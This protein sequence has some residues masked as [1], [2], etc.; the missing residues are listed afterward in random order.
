[1]SGS[2]PQSQLVDA[3]ADVARQFAADAG[4]APVVLSDRP[5]G[6]VVRVG[7]VVAKAHAPGSDAAA[8]GERLRAA[9]A[10]GGR[11]HRAVLLAPTFAEPRVV[12]ERLVSVW[13]ACTPLDPTAPDDAPWRHIG[14][15]LGRLHAVDATACGVDAGTPE[16]VVRALRALDEL[17]PSPAVAAVRAAF[18][19]LPRALLQGPGDGPRVLVHGDLHLG[20]VVRMGDGALRLID[21]DD[22]GRGDPRWDLA[23]PAA[24]FA[25][26]LMA[27][28]EWTALLR[29]YLDEGGAGWLTSWEA[30]DAFARAM[31]VQGAARA[32]ASA[33]RG[34][35]ALEETEAMYIDACVRMRSPTLASTP[36]SCQTLAQRK[37][38]GP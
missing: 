15:M 28:S 24:W 13:P 34:G 37:E 35:R 19:T 20:Q 1:M 33:A 2:P 25:M 18:E 7:D 26:G 27:E 32:L 6:C 12:C 31:V 30:L 9:A 11:G 22:L 36:A 5:D 8:L 23:R 38:R 10:L 4:S 14:A 17:P 29:G 3:L 21:V 16:R